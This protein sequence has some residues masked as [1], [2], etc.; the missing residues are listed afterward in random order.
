MRRNEKTFDE[1]NIN[2]DI[3]NSTLEKLGD[4]TPSN[5]PPADAPR[6]SICDQQESMVEDQ[7]YCT[8][9]A[10]YMTSNNA[11]RDYT[12]AIR[13]KRP[14]MTTVHGKM[15]L[16]GVAKADI[17]EALRKDAER[18]CDKARLEIQLGDAETAI[19]TLVSKTATEAQV[20]FIEDAAV[21]IAI[22]DDIDISPTP[23]E[24]KIGEVVKP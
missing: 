15:Y 10:D 5:I 14:Q 22:K 13:K 24:G 20:K 21:E 2:E 6:C 1:L 17:E 12:R 4:I 3:F 8:L 18:A 19:A 9:C 16:I 23:V 7:D 11:S